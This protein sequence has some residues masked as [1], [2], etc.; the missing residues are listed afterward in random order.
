MVIHSSMKKTLVFLIYLDLW[1]I[2]SCSGLL[3]LEVLQ[4]EVQ[5]S[6]RRKSMNIKLLLLYFK[7]MNH[8]FACSF[9]ITYVPFPLSVVTLV[10]SPNCP[11]T[12]CITISDIRSCLIERH[13]S[14]SSGEKIIKRYMNEPY[15][16]LTLCPFFTSS[17]VFSSSQKSQSFNCQIT[18]R[19]QLSANVLNSKRQKIN[20]LEK[21]QIDFV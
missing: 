10:F 19:F 21:N 8:S 1:Y 14:K 16:S 12:F 18:V 3:R 6:K 15:K 2:V 4:S 17:F 7:S 13:F 9:H 11:S 20:R 5:P